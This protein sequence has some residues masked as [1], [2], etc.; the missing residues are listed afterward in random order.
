MKKSPKVG[1]ATKLLSNHNYLKEVPVEGKTTTKFNFRLGNYDQYA[2]QIIRTGNCITLL[3]SPIAITEGSFWNTNYFEDLAQ[4]VFWTFNESFLLK[5][6]DKMQALS[7]QALSRCA[8]L[9]RENFTPYG[10]SL[11]VDIDEELK[12]CLVKND[13]LVKDPKFNQMFALD[14]SNRTAILKALET[15]ITAFQQ[16]PSS[17][18]TV[19]LSTIVP[20]VSFQ[21]MLKPMEGSPDTTL[22]FIKEQVATAGISFDLFSPLQKLSNGKNP[23]GLNGCMAAMIEFFYQHHYFKKEYSLEQIF[24]AYLQYS[25]N[26]IGK[27]KTFISEF[28]QDNSFIKYFHQLKRLKINKLP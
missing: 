4:Y 26:K 25:G 14:K 5:L 16:K 11:A 23:Y 22:A 28:R 24:T 21:D 20:E 19:N 15:K 17:S 7:F 18:V 3:S 1:F 27:L 8:E 13:H 12:W 2:A 6:V 9:L 10:S